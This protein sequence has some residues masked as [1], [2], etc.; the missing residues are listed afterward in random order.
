MKTFGFASGSL[1]N[2]SGGF[3]GPNAIAGR[4]IG[5]TKSEQV[6]RIQVTGISRRRRLPESQT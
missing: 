3:A 6:R 4:L 5:W 1:R 2:A